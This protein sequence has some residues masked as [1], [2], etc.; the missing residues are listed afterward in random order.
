MQ[1]RH[2]FASI[3]LT[4]GFLI[5]MMAPT[6]T[7]VAGQRRY[8]TGTLPPP[9]FADPE[10]ARKLATAFPEIERLFNNWVERQQMPGAVMGIII[11]GEMVW[12]KTGGVRDIKATRQSRP[13]QSFALHQ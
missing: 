1:R 9:R 11:D 6:T 13:T 7:L 8:A 3:S 10:R 2:H 4:L 12:L 5:L